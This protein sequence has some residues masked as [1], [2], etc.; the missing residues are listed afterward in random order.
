VL[1]DPDGKTVFEYAVGERSGEMAGIVEDFRAHTDDVDGILDPVSTNMVTVPLRSPKGDPIG[2]VQVVNKRG[3]PFDQG[4]VAVIEIMA[5]QVELAIENERLHEEARLATIVSFIG[6]ISHDVKNMVTPAM[7]GAQTLRFVSDDCFVSFDRRVDEII[8][9]SEHRQRIVGSLADLRELYP[10][11]TEMITAS[12]DVVQQRMA[13]ISA[14]VKGIV[15]EPNFEEADV[16]S[17]ARRVGT[18]LEPLGQE[19]GVAVTIEPAGDIPRATIDSKQ[20]YNAIYNLVFNAIDACE[21]GQAV[22]FRITGRAEGDFPDGNYVLLECIDNGPGI[23]DHVKEKLFTDQAIS[24][25]PM[26][27]G[28]GTRIVKNVIDAHGGLIELESA[29]GAGTTI[30]CGIPASRARQ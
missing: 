22:V 29:P 26:G 27:T 28:L 1:H 30:R 17:I 15:S 19:K 16:V 13:E 20:V 23:P 9:V 12:C 7:S 5:A 2:S 10:E 4:D 11:L 24:T 18:V 25:K 21:H 14:A 3:A 8:G 6:D